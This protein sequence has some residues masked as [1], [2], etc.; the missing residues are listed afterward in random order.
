MDINPGLELGSLSLSCIMII[1]A[2][3]IVLQLELLVLL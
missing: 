2:S 1:L 3:M